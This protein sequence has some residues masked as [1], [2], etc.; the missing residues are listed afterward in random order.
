MRMFEVPNLFD[1]LDNYTIK[2]ASLVDKRTK[3]LSRCGVTMDLDH[4][5]KY[6]RN[7]EN[8]IT[9][10]IYKYVELRQVL[11][12]DKSTS[13]RS[14]EANKELQLASIVACLSVL[15]KRDAANNYQSHMKE[16]IEAL[17]PMNFNDR[18]TILKASTPRQ[19]GKST[20]FTIVIVLLLL[21]SEIE[22]DV[23]TFTASEKKLCE[24]MSNNIKYFIETKVI[25]NKSL[26]KYNTQNFDSIIT[27]TEGSTKVVNVLLRDGYDNF[28]NEIKLKKVQ[29]RF[30]VSL[31]G[32][33]SWVIFVDEAAHIKQ[34]MYDIMTPIINQYKFKAM[35][36]FS[37]PNEDRAKE[38]VQYVREFMDIIKENKDN[39]YHNGRVYQSK[40]ICDECLSSSEPLKCTHMLAHKQRFDKC[41]IA[42]YLGCLK[43]LKEGQEEQ[44][45]HMISNCGIQLSDTQPIMNLQ[46]IQQIPVND[47]K[48][49][50][51]N[52]ICFFIDPPV[53]LKSKWAMNVIL[54]DRA[55]I[56]VDRSYLFNVEQCSQN[57]PYRNVPLDDPRSEEKAYFIC[58]GVLEHKCKEF[59]NEMI[60][61]ITNFLSQIQTTHNRIFNNEAIRYY[62]AIEKQGGYY[63]ADNLRNMLLKSLGHIKGYIPHMVS[64]VNIHS[65]TRTQDNIYFNTTFQSA[66]LFLNTL[67]TMLTK[68]ILHMS[69]K[70][71]FMSNSTQYDSII[72][73]LH[74]QVYTG[75][76]RNRKI[77]H[78]RDKPKDILMSFLFIHF[79]YRYANHEE[80]K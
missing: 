73:A 10:I 9:R 64:L 67:K 14:Y 60:S 7:D 71:V 12:T 62:H 43:K 59:A 52:D 6:P 44:E 1:L 26:L 51:I 46:L 42:H 66:I 15:I 36:C 20:S 29:A 2:K 8:P 54:I 61:A 55:G 16:A 17:S 13:L 50:N 77:E 32:L 28:T 56:Q 63:S 49:S 5:V 53:D 27:N 40:K 19:E 47:F 34:I 68:K 18:F 3:F 23:V 38:N 48:H 65:K 70:A 80:R 11:L 69:I 24:G 72:S 35:L 25:P 33:A 58:L 74:K 78:P 41:T 31:R 45:K 22:N 39:K 21:N 79:G 30:T 76:I 75:E 37:T 57:L 4:C